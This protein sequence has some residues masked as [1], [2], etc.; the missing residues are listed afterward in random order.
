MTYTICHCTNM[1]M[2]I[3]TFVKYKSAKTSNNKSLFDICKISHK[4]KKIS[5]GINIFSKKSS[6]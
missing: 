6:D 5:T 4:L 2:G 1:N 3:T